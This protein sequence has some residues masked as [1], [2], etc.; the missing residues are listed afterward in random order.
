MTFSEIA[1]GTRLYIDANIFVYHFTYESD[2]CG[3]LLER[4]DRREIE[5]YTGTHVLLEV[6]TGS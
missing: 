6:A 5:A 1:S 3:T 4:C 2:E